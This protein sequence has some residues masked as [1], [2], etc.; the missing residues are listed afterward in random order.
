MSDYKIKEYSFNRAKELNVTIEPS[1]NKNKKID[2]YNK[3]GKIAEIGDINYSDYPTYLE[4]HGEYFANHRRRLYYAR[5]ANDN[6]LQGL[7]AKLIL[8]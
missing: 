5:H 3:T 4:T 6:K 8:W 2:V 7:Y 1:S